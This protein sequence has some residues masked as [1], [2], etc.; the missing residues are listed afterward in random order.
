MVGFYIGKIRP[1]FASIGSGKSLFMAN[2]VKRYVLSKL[3]DMASQ[4]M[5]L[6][7]FD[8]T[9]ACHLYAIILQR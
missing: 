4:S 1:M 5:K 6:T 3:S 9:G 7:G 2:N 8:R